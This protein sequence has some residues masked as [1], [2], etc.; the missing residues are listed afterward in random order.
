M[1]RHRLIADLELEDET[2]TYAVPAGFETDFAS[3][4]PLRNIL[5]FG[6]FA[7]LVEYGNYSAT[8]HD[9]LY[10]T[11]R[12]SRKQADDIF[13]RALLAE[14]VDRW[15][16]WLFWSGVRIGGAK[17]YNSTPTSSGFSSSGD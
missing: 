5:L 10:A 14:G 2:G 16:A 12:V 15:R 7:L 8:V 1:S 3:I 4:E 11:G 9:W 13:Y 17:Q 6:L